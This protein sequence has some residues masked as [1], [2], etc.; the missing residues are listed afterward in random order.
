MTAADARRRFAAGDRVV[1]R[2]GNRYDSLA[3]C[4]DLPMAGSFGHVVRAYDDLVV[5][6]I[7]GHTWHRN[8]CGGDPWHFDPKEIEHAD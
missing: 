2:E 4:D 5:V 8:H 3:P 6:S 7:E 1:V